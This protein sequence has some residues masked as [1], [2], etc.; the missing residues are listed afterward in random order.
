[1][2]VHS[3][4]RSGSETKQSI[5]IFALDTH[6]HRFLDNR[7]FDS[8]SSLIHLLDDKYNKSDEEVPNLI[9]HFYNCCSKYLLNN[10]NCVD[11]TTILTSNC[12]SLLTKY[13]SLCI[14]LRSMQYKID[15]ICLQ[16]TWCK[17]Q[18]PYEIFLLENY[19]Y[20]ATCCRAT[21]HGGLTIYINKDY[22]YKCKHYG[23][24]SN[25]W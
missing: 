23:N 13:D 2:K 8:K 3:L 19:N 21:K 6:I 20:V 4:F 17:T 15:V 11:G 12:Q 22:D 25:I 9:T 24:H 1:M 16:E 5:I 7:D 10:I 18:S 14:P